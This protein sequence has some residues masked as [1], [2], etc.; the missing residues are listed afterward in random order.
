MY[1]VS[2]YTAYTVYYTLYTVYHGIQYIIITV[3]HVASLSLFNFVHNK[4]LINP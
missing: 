2:L 1:G 3:H 4:T